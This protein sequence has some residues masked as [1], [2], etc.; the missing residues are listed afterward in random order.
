MVLINRHPIALVHNLGFSSRIVE[1]QKLHQNYP[2]LAFQIT[3]ST[4]D[5][6]QGD[7]SHR[8]VLGVRQNDD[9]VS[10]GRLSTTICLYEMK[11]GYKIEGPAL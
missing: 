6:E 1:I 8:G 5:E 4:E 2:H 9:K 7:D 3:K 11:A 10:F